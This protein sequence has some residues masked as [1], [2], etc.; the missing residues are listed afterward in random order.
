MNFV[1]CC[2]TISN[3]LLDTPEIAWCMQDLDERSVLTG[4]PNPFDSHTR[5]QAIIDKC[6]ANNRSQLIWVMQGIWYHWRRG[7]IGAL[8]VADIKGTAQTGNRGLADLMLFKSLL[9]TAVLAKAATL[10]PDSADWWGMTVSNLAESYKSWFLAE[11]Q[12]SKTWRA[13]HAP[14]ESKFLGFLSDVVFGKVYDGPIKLAIKSSK[15][16]AETLQMPGLVEYL[17]E[18]EAKLTLENGP[19]DAEMGVCDA[20]LAPSVNLVDDIVFHL[21]AKDGNTQSTT[22]RASAVQDGPK[23][24]MLDSIILNTRQLIEAQIQMVVQEPVEPH[25]HGLHAAIMATP[26]GN[27]RGSPNPDDPA[28]SK[29]IG[30]FYDPKLS[31]EANHRPQLRVPPLRYELFKRLIELARG[32]FGPEVGDDIPEGDLC[33]LS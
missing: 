12:G 31:G 32:R 9:K 6:R 5:L 25:P 10:F 21:P 16:A 33:F 28:S 17:Q 24:E 3:K 11:E 18:V 15:T 1:D 13:G 20:S 7:N 14:S 29:Y 27:L 30:V 8:S 4:I 2:A 22:I 26:V 19:A 23:R